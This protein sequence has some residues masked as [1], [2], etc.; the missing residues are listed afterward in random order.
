MAGRW[1]PGAT[2]PEQILDARSGRIQSRCRGQRHDLGR[3]ISQV[4]VVGL[5]PGTRYVGYDGRV[6]QALRSIY[7]GMDDFARQS[8]AA[9]FADWVRKAQTIYPKNSKPGIFRDPVE[10]MV[11][12]R[13]RKIPDKE[14]EVLVDLWYTNGQ[15]LTRYNALPRDAQIRVDSAFDLWQIATGRASSTLVYDG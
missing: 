4:L 6:G 14:Y 1:V 11:V 7:Y 8:T 12:S 13:L 9:N 5:S 3:L 2:G 10:G 15:E